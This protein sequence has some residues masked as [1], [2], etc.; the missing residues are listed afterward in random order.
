MSNSTTS[1][2]ADAVRALIAR[3]RYQSGD[4]LPAERE[5][6]EGLGVSRPTMREALRHLTQAGLLAPRH[7]SGT[8]VAE[9]DLDAVFAVRMQLEP[10]A[11]SLA[12][13]HRSTAHVHHLSALVKRLAGELDRPAAYAATDL[14]IHAVITDA[15]SNP[16]LADVLA[17]LLELAKLSRAITS[18]EREARTATLRHMRPLVRAIS[19]RDETAAARAMEDHLSTVRDIARSTSLQYPFDRQISTLSAVSRRQTGAP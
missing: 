18:P 13:R 17:R 14:E 15:A 8:Y 12:A 6:A 3:G 4:R 9:V 16:V 10:Y 2:A 5:L 19:S 11:A 7:G 1:Q